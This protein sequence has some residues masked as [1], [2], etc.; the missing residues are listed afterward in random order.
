MAMAL[1]SGCSVEDSGST[2]GTVRGTVTAPDPQQFVTADAQ[3][4]LSRLA[5]LVLSTVQADVV[6]LAPVAGAT[7]D[8]VRLN[9]TGTVIEVLDS[10]TTDSDGGYRFTG[11]PEPTDSSLAL[12]VTGQTGTMRAIITGGIVNVSPVTEAVTAELFA[13][14]GGGVA[15]GN[16]TVQEVAALYSVMQ[17]MDVDVTGLDFGDAVARIRDEAGPGSLFA[18]LLG[19][20]STAGMA[21]PL[22]DQAYSLVE[23]GGSLRDAALLTDGSGGLELESGTGSLIFGSASDLPTPGILSYGVFWHDLDAVHD[24]RG[25][26]EQPLPFTLSLSN[27]L[28]VVDGQ[29]HVVTADTANPAAGAGGIGAL[30]PDGSLMAYPVQNATRTGSGDLSVLGAGIRIAPRAFLPTGQELSLPL[31]VLDAGGGGTAYH[32][33][34]LR[35]VFSGTASGANAVDF[36]TLVGTTTYD[37]TPSPQPF[38]D[39]DI[40]NYGGF[41]WSGATDSL[42]LD[43]ASRSLATAAG[44]DSQNGFYY[45]FPNSGLIQLRKDDGGLWGFAATPVDGVRDGDVVASHTFSNTFSVSPLL[46]VERTFA[47]AIRQASGMT[48]GAVAGDYNVVEYTGY[49]GGD[50]TATPPT[51]FVQG[52]VRYGTLRLASNGTVDSVS[53]LQSRASLALAAAAPVAVANAS[54]PS[55]AFTTAI[56]GAANENFAL[57]VAGVPVFSFTST[58]PGDQVA[59]ID[60][61]AGLDSAPVQNAFATLGITVDGSVAGGDLVFTR[62]DGTPFDI[63]VTNDFSSTASAAGGFAG[64]DFSPGTHSI[65]GGS[66]AQP[67]VSGPSGAFETAVAGA[68]GED[69]ALEV[70][71]VPVFTFTSAAAGDEVAAADIQAALDD[72]GVQST[73]SAAGIAASG[74]VA[75]GN[76]AFARADGTPFALTVTNDFS[77]TASLAGGFAGADFASGAPHTVANGT[78]A[79]ANASG[80]A[81]VFTPAVAGAAGEA[82]ALTVGG[83]PVFSFT[84]AAIGDDV[85][86]EEIQGGVDAALADLTTAG[87]AVS[88]TVATSDLAF[89]RADGAAFDIVVTDG[90]SAT[91]GGFDGADF[92]ADAP[93]TIDNGAPATANASG[94]SGAFTTATAGGAGEALSLVV[95]GVTAFTF[96]SAAA[97]DE[98]TAA[99]VQGGVDAAASSLAA[100][101][102]TASGSVAGGDL[103]FTK[104]DGTSFDIVVTN[105]FSGEASLAGGFAGADFAAGTRDIDNGTVAGLNASG[106]S[107]AFTSALAGAAGESFQLSVGGVVVFSFTAAAA[108]DQVTAEAIQ[109]GIDAKLADLT[110]AGIAVSGSVAGGDLAFSRADG[111]AFD[112]V[113]ANNFSGT[114]STAGG[115]AGTDFAVGGR[116]IDNGAAAVQGPS[117]AH[118]S[119]QQGATGSYLVNADGQMTLSLSIGGETVSGSGAVTQSGDFAAFAI[120]S[121]DG[122]NQGRG[123]LLLLRQP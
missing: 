73:L 3:G 121:S 27:T 38:D 68:A 77:G 12:R 95:G 36:T 89:S 111:A 91:P 51:G 93:H 24:E 34:G 46:S 104:A 44:T 18:Q 28:H 67:N 25:G 58:A 6:G 59:A 76:L 17:G 63:V 15:L 92:T 13:N 74:T 26:T 71:G 115:F 112:I 118:A 8:L 43:L 41:V 85:T 122:T 84:S 45:V 70:G 105:D 103:V 40:Q 83:V 97:G 37:S 56:A 101:G 32:Q 53:L 82:F 23:F 35:E 123:V 60:I 107:G 54:G 61:Q 33:I 14:L 47:V 69:F 98:V 65:D 9:G 102:I 5:S 64:A 120:T 66:A 88:G 52:A 116:T 86:A 16:Y 110:A 55:G 49:V 113:L 21:T 81:G 80:A 119:V 117:L 29:G 2:P 42:T 39:G 1:L 57:E 22:R 96:T 90:F 87:I 94:A 50:D 79:V 20:F 75:G 106:P 10:Q 7:I 78:G 114:T 48:A 99:D 108:G 31:T 62:T 19:N 11:A 72:T 4:V 109:G 30:T 100:A